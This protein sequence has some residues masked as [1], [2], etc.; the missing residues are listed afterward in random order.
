MATQEQEEAARKQLQETLSNLSRF[1]IESLIRKDLGEQASFEAGRETFMRTIRLFQS[2]ST[3]DLGLFPVPILNQLNSSAVAA[4]N[5]FSEIQSFHLGLTNPLDVRNNLIIRIQNEFDS[6]YSVV[7]P[8]VTYALSRETSVDELKSQVQDAQSELTK[9][10]QNQR[11][12]TADREKEI[13]EMLVR[14]RE[15][16]SEAGVSQNAIFFSEEAKSHTESAKGWFYATIA[17][18]ILTAFF[19]GFSI[20]GFLFGDPIDAG[21]A[22]QLAV[23]K[24]LGFS[25]L[26]YALNWT[27]KNYR[28]HRHNTVVNR[29]RHNALSTFQAFS[30]ATADDGVRN[31]VLVRSCETIFSPSPSGYDAPEASRDS[32]PQ[33]VEIIRQVGNRDGS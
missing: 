14:M 17:M 31:A 8:H 25:I 18:A 12:S 30:D 9:Q 27:A 24:L 20:Y 21:Q 26:F 19:A 5:S 1:T 29:H 16:A 2:V 3:S 32:N 11:K 15:H 6:Q 22:I 13:E 4:I 7:V 33:I 23:G 28:S 10:I